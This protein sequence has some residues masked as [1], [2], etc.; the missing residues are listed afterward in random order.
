MKTS[1]IIVEYNPFHQGHK[2]HINKTREI[3]NSDY[4]V[5]LMSG[6]FTQRG[7]PAICDKWLRTKMALKGGAD[8]II[9]L[10]IIYS[11]RSAEYFAQASVRLLGSL[12]II[13]S[14]VFGSEYDN[15]DVLNDI[16]KI[17]LSNDQYYEKRLK[18]YLQKGSPFP[19]A[20][21]NALIDLIKLKKENKFLANHN[22]F[23]ILNGSNNILGI[24]YLKAKHKHDINI[25]MKTIKRIGQNY[26][27]EQKDKDYISATAVRNSIYNN[28]LAEI[29]DKLPK[30][31]YQMLDDEI[32]NNKIPINKEHLGI[33]LLSIIRKM[34]VENLSKIQDINKDLAL[35]IKKAA[36]NSGNYS[37]LL[38]AL[39]TRAY[40]KTRFQRILLNILFNLEK[41]IIKKH[42][43]NGPSYLRILGFN[44]KGEKLIAEISKRA[45]LPIIYNPSDYI[46]EISF[47]KSDNLKNSL[48][49]DIYATDIYNLL[50][51]DPKQRKAGYDF[52]KK[53]VRLD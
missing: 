2:Y 28:N 50:Y 48:S 24:E 6:H 45:K 25:E 4:V 30:F 43:E 51:Q 34:T 52:I 11:I 26:Y 33:I 32:K 39:N 38:T 16:A 13:D 18:N 47:N 41:D 10:P 44:K 20:R 9:E 46:K 23:D 17:L 5:A 31:T 3:T 40:T 8:L 42:D 19:N 37:Q 7:T 22:I 36:K 35:R 14:I 12:N 29:K 49:L 53:L 15:I 1:G 27:S 21:K